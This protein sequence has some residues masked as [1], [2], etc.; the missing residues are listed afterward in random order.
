MAKAACIGFSH[1]LGQNDSNDCFYGGD[2]GQ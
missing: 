1:D 2:M